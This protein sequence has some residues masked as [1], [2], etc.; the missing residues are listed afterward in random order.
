M[1]RLKQI[2]VN[3]TSLFAV[4][5]DGTF[6][7]AELWTEGDPQWRRVKCPPEGDDHPELT[8]EEIGERL[9]KK[10]RGMIIGRGK[11]E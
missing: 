4:A 2:A 1:R 5:E 3:E 8:I 10:S 7:R 11:K 9:K 6:W